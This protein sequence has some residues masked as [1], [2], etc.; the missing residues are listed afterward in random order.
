MGSIMMFFMK[1]LNLINKSILIDWS[2]IYREKFTFDNQSNKF[3]LNQYK[4]GDYVPTETIQEWYSSDR[5]IA[6][7]TARR[8][9]SEK[10]IDLLN[11]PEAMPMFTSFF[12]QMGEVGGLKFKN[13]FKAIEEGDGET[14][15]KEALDSDWYRDKFTKKRA[16]RFA[17]FLRENV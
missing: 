17:D 8:V 13:M 14:A 11:N 12:F 3:E 15:Y 7:D 16:K 5:K 6:I 10:N 2:V 4:K 1:L 9:L